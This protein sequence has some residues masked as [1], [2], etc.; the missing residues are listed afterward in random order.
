MKNNITWMYVLGALL[1]LVGG[2]WFATHQHDFMLRSCGLLAALVGTG[3][4]L[5]SR[6]RR[7]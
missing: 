2:I 1:I 6:K 3:L 7:G 5:K 4:V